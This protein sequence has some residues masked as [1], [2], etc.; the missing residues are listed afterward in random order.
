MIRKVE[1]IGVQVSDLDRS[2]D[3]YQ[4][5]LGFTL[6]RREKIPGIGLEIALLRVGDSYVELLKYEDRP[7]P[8]GKAPLGHFA[9]QVDDIETV[10]EALS[11]N[12]V[13]IP[14][15][16]PQVVFDGQARIF[17][18][19]GPDGEVVELFQYILPLSRGTM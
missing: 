1:H 13:K 12:G 15:G 19:N 9:L 16:T 11:R 17:F 14:G 5:V 3:F 18:I 4:R 7:V 2:L 8:Q 6:H 10:L